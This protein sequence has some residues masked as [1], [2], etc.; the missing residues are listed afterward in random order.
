LA[1]ALIFNAF[2]AGRR[3]LGKYLKNLDFCGISPH[4]ASRK[5]PQL[6]PMAG[7]L[8]NFPQTQIRALAPVLVDRDSLA[9]AH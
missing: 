9:P 1:L 6:E 4:L 8:R 5:L 3:G 7:S 2:A